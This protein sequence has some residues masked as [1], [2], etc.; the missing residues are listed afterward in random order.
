MP[1][2]NAAQN[3]SINLCQKRS[4]PRT[5][6][7]RCCETVGNLYPKATAKNKENA[8]TYEVSASIPACTAC[9]PNSSW[10]IPSLV[11]DR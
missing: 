11:S 8:Y 10:A 5:Y 9:P 2:V 7:P 1:S 3:N 6:K 4:H